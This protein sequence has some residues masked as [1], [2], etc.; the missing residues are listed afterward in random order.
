MATDFLDGLASIL[1]GDR[2][3]GSGAFVALASAR[4][5][6]LMI[7][8]PFFSSRILP[9]R[10]RAGL[11]FLF[12]V[13]F[14]AAGAGVVPPGS[15]G[16]AAGLLAQ[17]SSAV[18]ALVGEG[19]VGIALGWFGFLVMAA[20]RGAAVLA[21]EAI[22]LSL[23]GPAGDEGGAEPAL[24]SLQAAFALY[25]FLALDLHH[26]FL[27]AAAA[28]FVH[29]PPGS[30][31]EAGALAGAGKAAIAAAKG[32]FAVI[33]AA[34]FPV[35]AALMLAA[36]AQGIAARILPEAEFLLF[37]FPARAVLGM[38][39]TAAALPVLADLY[40]RSFEAACRQGLDLIRGFFA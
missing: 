18:L 36:V 11:A 2:A 17:P 13:L 35:T 39:V 5:L 38:A 23:G 32:L 26:A 16:P 12:A 22:G 3:R 40:G 7:S 28:S 20:V 37:G 29:L 31:L 30:L 15:G 6:G 10:F 21:A 1:S 19:A 25:V 24:R 33:L 14:A 9:F 4:M 27:K 8:V 34:A